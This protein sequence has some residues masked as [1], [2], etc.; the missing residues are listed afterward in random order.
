[1][2]LEELRCNSNVRPPSLAVNPF[3]SLFHQTE[4]MTVR[5]VNEIAMSSIQKSKNEEIDEAVTILEEESNISAM[6]S[7]LIQILNAF[8]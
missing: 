2:P 6:I 1:M 3:F 5:L 7:I 4:I 8:K